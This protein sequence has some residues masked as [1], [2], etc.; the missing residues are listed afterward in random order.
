AEF[1]RG[2]AAGPK[3]HLA[4]FEAVARNLR[5]IYAESAGQVGTTVSR[6][7]HDRLRGLAEEGL[8]RL[9][10]LIDSRAARG[11]TC[12]GHG[13]LNLDHVYHFPDAAPPGDLVIVDCIEFTDRFRFLDP[14]A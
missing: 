9:R 4:R 11:L 2:A 7:V 13:D 10:P 1:H 12:D 8:D 14:V 3:A 5:D 6:A